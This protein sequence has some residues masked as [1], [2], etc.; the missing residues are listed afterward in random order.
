MS[1]NKGKTS[2]GMEQ[3]L[4]GLLCYVLWWVTGIIF[5]TLEKDNKFVRFHAIQSIVVFGP[6]TVLFVIFHYIPVIGWILNWVLGIFAFILWIVLMVKAYRGQMYKLPV[7]GD[8]A[9]KN[10]KP[11]TDNKPE[12]K[13][14][15]P[16]LSKPLQREHKQDRIIWPFAIFSG[17]SETG[18]HYCYVYCACLALSY[19]DDLKNLP[20]FPKLVSRLQFSDY[21]SDFR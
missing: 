15:P 16:N 10:S 13:K 5:L 8:I 3:N 19:L 2:T 20:D 14:Y 12:E 11:M 1:E 21:R 6:V 7:A 9:E 17:C 18:A 4:E